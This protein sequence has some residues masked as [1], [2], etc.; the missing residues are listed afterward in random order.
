MGK[1]RH[2][3]LDMIRGVVILAI[4]FININYLSTPSIARYNPLVLG[5]FSLFD[6][7]VWFFEYSLIKQRFMPI[8]AVMFGVGICLFSQSY[9]RRNESPVAAYLKRSVSLIVIGL[10]HAYLIWDG[11]ILVAYAICGLF[12]FFARNLA[13][14][15]LVSLGVVLIITP[16]VPDVYRAIS[17]LI[18]VSSN[19]NDVT[20]TPD[21]WATD[22]KK[23]DE[24]VRAY[25]GSWLSL[26]PARVETALSRQTSDLIYFTLWRCTGL[27]LIGIALARSGFFEGEGNYQVGL[28]I[29]LGIGL[30][31]STLSSY[32]YIQSGFD[33]Q[34]F[35]TVLSLCFYVGTLS[36]AYAY[37]CLLVLWGCSD[38]FLKLKSAL[39]KVG[40]VALTLYIAQ[41]LICAFIFYGWGLGLYGK[42]CRGELFFI[43]LVILAIQFIFAQVWF[44]R[45]NSG[46]LEYLWRLCYRGKPV[47][48]QN[49]AITDS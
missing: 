26:T 11:D 10:A 5:D 44:R 48:K 33:Y 19:I 3:N 43:T 41:S 47:L 45:F 2:M 28:A 12:A 40:R 20:T 39:A 35:T 37:L 23:V 31:A 24:M 7:W 32:F 9:F 1:S 21:F 38:Q 6:Q 16:V 49:E 25:D 46:P 42:V 36:L 14:K 18:A 13:V 29:G 8:L 27:M 34:F 17:E 15:W 30:P 22:L 4:L